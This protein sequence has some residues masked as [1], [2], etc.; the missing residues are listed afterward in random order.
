MRTSLLVFSTSVAAGF[1]APVVAAQQSNVTTFIIV[2][3]KD[4][5]SLEQFTRDGNTVTGVW[6]SNQNGQ[7]QVHDYALTLGA[8]GSP[9]RYEMAVRF[10]DGAGNLPPS[11][12]KYSMQFGPDSL[13]LVTGRTKP[14]TQH[15]AMKGGAYPTYGASLVGQE[16]GLVR[17]RA[18]HADSGGIPFTTLGAGR[19]SPLQMLEAKFV[20]TDSA[21]VGTTH[22]RVDNAGHVLSWRM[23]SGAEGARVAPIDVKRFED[24]LLAA[25]AAAEAAARAAHV[26]TLSAAVLDRLVGEYPLNPTTN[27]TI[28]RDDNK[29]TLR[30]GG[31]PPSLLLP[32]SGTRFFLQRAMSGQMIDF[33]TDAAGNAVALMLPQA[34]GTERRIPKSPK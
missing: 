12:A 8:D 24:A 2:Q 5:V 20:G 11:E 31:Q 19:A 29:L 21:G 34:G 32:E 27:I 9:S 23:T 3:G 22:L 15:L 17:L 30:V 6:I 28:A 14:L 16:I 13:L 4:T 26:V 33:E 1:F 18:A 10:P 7:V 25:D